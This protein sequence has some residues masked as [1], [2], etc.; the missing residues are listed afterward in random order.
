MEFFNHGGH[1]VHRA[2]WRKYVKS[3]QAMLNF[4]WIKITTLALQTLRNNFAG[5]AWNFLTTEDSE[6]TELNGE[7]M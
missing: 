5:F 2:E 1:G 4:S 3:L 7:N 6:G